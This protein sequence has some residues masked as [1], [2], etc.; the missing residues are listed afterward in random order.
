MPLACRRNYEV[1]RKLNR[2]RHHESIMMFH[3]LDPLAPAITHYEDDYTPVMC[4]THFRVF[5]AM[6]KYG[7]TRAETEVHHYAIKMEYL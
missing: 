5:S 6:V 3:E 4:D 7:F 2:D 1:I